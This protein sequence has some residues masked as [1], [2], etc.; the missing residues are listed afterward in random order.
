MTSSAERDATPPEPGEEERRQQKRHV[1]TF[2]ACRVEGGGK[3]HIGIV[4]NISPGGAQIESKLDL[5]VGETLTYCWDGIPE[6]E[7]EIVWREGDRIGVRNMLP[8]EG[9]SSE[10]PPR[11]VR[12]PADLTCRVWQGDRM[13][14]AQVANISQTGMR[15]EGE[16]DL[17]PGFQVTVE[18]GPLVMPNTTVRWCADGAAG[19]RFGSPM[20]MAV[21]MTLLS[22]ETFTSHPMP[23]KRAS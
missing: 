9:W 17:D 18:I 4:R 13:H 11:A 6:I 23:G 16:L 12:I 10:F 19:L 1:T 22:D 15:C 7:A 14:E 5:P 3:A 20:R 21:L 8:V 2:R